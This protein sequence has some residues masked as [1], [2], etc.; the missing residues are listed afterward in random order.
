MKRIIFNVLVGFF[1]FVIGTAITNLF[2]SQVTNKQPIVVKNARVNDCSFP[3]YKPN[4]TEEIPGNW[5]TVNHEKFSFSIPKDMK[6]KRI[7][8]PDVY[9]RDYRNGWVYKNQ[10][11]IMSFDF[12]NY[13]EGYENAFTNLPT[14]KVEKTVVDGREA[15]IATWDCVERV[16]EDDPLFGSL[17]YFPNLGEKPKLIVTAAFDDRAVQEDAKKIFRSIRFKDSKNN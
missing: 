8:F 16:R 1:S 5:K 12:G 7:K 4:T 13:F 2:V 14:Y 15:I 9:G 11:I 17:V 10:N 3:N 6:G